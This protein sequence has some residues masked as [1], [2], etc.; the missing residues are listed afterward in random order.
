LQFDLDIGDDQH[1]STSL[2]RLREMT[3]NM[4][5]GEATSRQVADTVCDFP[6]V[7]L[8]LVG[9]QTDPAA[10]PLLL[11]ISSASL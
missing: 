1:N 7:P 8:N 9:E 4:A 5:T 10:Q 3:F 6:R 11:Y 2:P